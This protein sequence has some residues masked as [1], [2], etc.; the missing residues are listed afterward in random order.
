[1]ACMAQLTDTISPADTAPSRAGGG[2]A[3]F[4]LTLCVSTLIA[5][6]FMPVSLLSPI[7]ADLRL[8]EGQAGQAIR[9]SGLL[10]LA[11]SLFIASV[12]RNIDRRA[13]LLWLTGAMIASGLITTF[14][15]S[16]ALLMA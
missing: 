14:A 10:A 7:A 12:S 5:S 9:V 6:E 13:L 11:A 2:A 16:F 15:P 1:M 8:T 4:A 3:V